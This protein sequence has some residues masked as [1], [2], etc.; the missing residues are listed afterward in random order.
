MT[1]SADPEMEFSRDQVLRDV[2]GHRVRRRW[3]VVFLILVS[4]VRL[5]VQFH[6][7]WLAVGLVVVGIPLY[8]SL[9]RPGGWSYEQKLDRWL[10]HPEKWRRERNGTL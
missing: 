9:W 8:E 1:E 5:W 3:V 10:D 2:A 6:I 7:W 4:A